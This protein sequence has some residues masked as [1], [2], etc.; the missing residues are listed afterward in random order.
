[1][2][3]FDEKRQHFGIDVRSLARFASPSCA[4]WTEAR[5]SLDVEYMES[6]G[7]P[8]N[9]RRQSGPL[10]KPPKQINPPQSQESLLCDDRSA[11]EF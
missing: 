7:D 5:W 1:M 4:P 6:D 8:F 3:I 10:S 9:K 11:S 2:S